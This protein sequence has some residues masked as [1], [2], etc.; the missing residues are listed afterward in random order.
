[1]ALVSSSVLS[2][3][4]NLCSKSFNGDSSKLGSKQTFAIRL[5]IITGLLAAV[6]VIVTLTFRRSAA[7]E[8]ILVEKDALKGDR[9]QVVQ[10]IEAVK[11]FIREK[12]PEEADDFDEIGTTILREYDN[13]IAALDREN[14]SAAN[15]IAARYRA[16]LDG[17]L[18]RLRSTKSPSV[19]LL[20]EYLRKVQQ[21]RDGDVILLLQKRNY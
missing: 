18:D 14:V 9:A 8:S 19:N 1:M 11:K 10:A 5:V 2:F 17:F 4:S 15:A 3:L 13:R 7:S 16:I 12:C 20:R 6:L 21:H